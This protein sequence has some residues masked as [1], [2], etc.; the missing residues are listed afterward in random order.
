M[1]KVLFYIVVWAIR[2]ILIAQIGALLRA[3]LSVRREDGTAR[4][5]FG[6]LSF[7]ECAI[8]FAVSIA[9]ILSD[10]DLAL[11]PIV[12]GLSITANILVLL[13]RCRLIMVGEREVL[14][15]L[16]SLRTEQ[17]SCRIRGISLELDAGGHRY[18]IWFPMIRWDSVE[19]MLLCL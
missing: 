8:A 17:L 4:V 3:V 13:I 6:F 7:A 14:V 5:L 12:I 19:R 2:L 1:E 10:I 16:H 18:T 15:G 11:W 9:A